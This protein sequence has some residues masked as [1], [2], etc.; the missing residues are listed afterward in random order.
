MMQR[1]RI[2][3]R[4]TDG[5]EGADMGHSGLKEC[6]C[7]RAACGLA[8]KIVY[9]GWQLVQ[10]WTYDTF[11]SRKSSLTSSSGFAVASWDV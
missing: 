1:V 4:G 9:H 11:P 2:P 3:Y 5:T 10:L 8:G 7:R 6:A